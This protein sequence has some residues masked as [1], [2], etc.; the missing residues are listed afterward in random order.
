MDKKRFWKR[1]FAVVSVL[2]VAC[3]SILGI[4]GTAFIAGSAF[5]VVRFDQLLDKLNYE[6]EL[7]NPAPP[8]F[9]E[10]DRMEIQPD[11]KIDLTNLSV[12]GDTENIHN[13]F[14]LGVDS[15]GSGDRGRSDTMMILSV[16]DSAKTIK[17][18]SL[19]RDTWATIPGMDWDGDGYDDYAKLNAAYASG[20]FDLLN[21]TVRQNFRLDIDKYVA[22]DFS[23]FAAAVDALGGVNVEVDGDAVTW[24]PKEDPG[25][26]DRFACDEYGNQLREPIGYTAGKYT[27]N[28]YQALAFCRVRKCYPSSDF[29]RQQNQRDVVSALISKAKSSSP[30]KLYSMAE[31]VLPAVTTN[32]TRNEIEGYIVN[33]L[34]YAGYTIETEYHLPAAGEFENL[35]LGA[36]G[37]WIK[38]PETTVRALHEY[39]YG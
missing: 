4:L 34:K 15:R 35:N 23:G 3:V 14:L 25:D 28:G 26:P 8:V 38:D 2:K 9:S 33:V 11:A 1:G 29:V 17:L 20:G 10:A 19:L 32:M 24:I 39:I 18:I 12:R 27:L 31:N 16:N 21:K 37:L 13:Y 30:A 6:T 22:V 5:A 36:A 7:V